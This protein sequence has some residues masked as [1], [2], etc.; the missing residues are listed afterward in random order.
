MKLDLM[1]TIN[2]KK[3]FILV[4]MLLAVIIPVQSKTASSAQKKVGQHTI[5]FKITN[6][7][8]LLSAKHDLELVMDLSASSLPDK[9]NLEIAVTRIFPSLLAG[10][11]FRETIHTYDRFRYQRK[12]QPII[13]RF[14]MQP[15]PDLPPAVSDYNVSL[16]V[17]EGQR[18]EIRQA[19]GKTMNQ[20]HIACPVFVGS[21]SLALENVYAETKGMLEVLPYILDVYN[22]SQKPQ[23]RDTEPNVTGRRESPTAE[24]ASDSD[25]KYSSSEACKLIIRRTT[26]YTHGQKSMTMPDIAAIALSV[27]N[28]MAQ[29]LRFGAKP[30]MMKEFDRYCAFG[31]I[32]VLRNSILY[33]HYYLDNAY[34]KFDEIH[35]DLSAGPNP[36][37]RAQMVAEWQQ[38]DA[39][40]RKLWQ[41]LQRDYFNNKNMVRIRNLSFIGELPDCYQQQ[42]A[43]N[44]AFRRLVM[45]ENFT[46]TMTAYID[47]LNGLQLAY[48]E[49]LEREK[50]SA[51]TVK[52]K[53]LKK[54]IAGLDHKIRTDLRIT[55]SIEEFQKEKAEALKDQ[56]KPSDK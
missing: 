46:D 11:G 54:K 45:K 51:A 27:R 33:L 26:K 22:N 35:Q 16:Q 31:E 48:A 10:E 8:A 30:G 1:P 15:N 50:T 28:G 49:L 39:A 56:E 24:D 14:S 25:K 19:L 44:A 23:P 7:V 20:L 29:V 42:E 55:G 32:I 43:D 2:R 40:A 12:G 17:A 47:K 41:H 37:L 5:A 13:K 3:T 36:E 34:R 4:T 38:M 53:S 21:K 9:T 6:E 52:I 18:M